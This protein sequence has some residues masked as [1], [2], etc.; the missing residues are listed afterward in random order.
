MLLISI[1]L[2]NHH[3]TFNSSP[4]Q[5]NFRLVQIESICRLQNKFDSKMEICF[6]KGRKHKWKR[7]K[8]CLPAFCPFPTF[9][10]GLLCRVIKICHFVV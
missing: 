10:K 3:F 1:S 7:T 6:G 9:S 5:Q 4:K 2:T 8:C